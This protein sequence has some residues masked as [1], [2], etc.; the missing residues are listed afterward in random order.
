MQLLLILLTLINPDL[1]EDKVVINKTYEL[2]NPSQMAVVIS[3]IHGDVV[4]EKSEDNKVYLSLTIE[5]SAN[6]DALL[7]K[8]KNELELGERV[9]ADSLM[10]FTKAPFIKRCRWG[11]NSGYDMRDHPKYD[12]KYQ[13]KIKVPKD[14]KLEAKTIDHGDVRV[15]N[16]DGPVKVGN[17]NGKVDIKNARRVLQASTVNGDV[18]INFLESPKDPIDFNTVNGDFNFELPDNF[19]AQVYFNSMNGYLYTSFDYKK[20]SPK[21]EKSEK[22]GKFKIGTKA[23]VEIGSGGPELS[24]RSINGNVYLKRA[25]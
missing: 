1:K 2:A 19:S 17:V 20:M 5:M 10:F 11:N 3:N 8:A 18:N 4:V 25:D 22:N 15:E 23:G 21:V 16:I 9:T 6:S 12:F 24:F 7:E 13:Y 14:V